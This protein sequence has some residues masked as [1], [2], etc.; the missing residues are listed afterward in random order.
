MYSGAGCDDSSSDLTTGAL[1]GNSSSESSSSNSSSRLTLGFC[2]AAEL[3]ASSIAT[4]WV[5][6]SGLMMV[7]VVP[8]A[9]STDVDSGVIECGIFAATSVVS[10]LF[11][12]GASML[13]M[14]ILVNAT[15][16]SAHASSRKLAGNPTNQLAGALSMH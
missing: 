16:A 13:E 5:S 8:D 3:G 1:D 6:G 4:S 11:C 7:G 9:S 10:V 2:S 12:M 15:R 14:S